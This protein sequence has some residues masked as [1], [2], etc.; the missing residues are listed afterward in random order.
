MKAMGLAVFGAPGPPR[1]AYKNRYFPCVH[2]MFVDLEQVSIDR[3]DFEPDYEDV[4]GHARK[5]DEPDRDRQPSWPDPAK[6]RKRRFVGTS[7]DVSSRIAVRLGQRL[8][9]SVKPAALVRHDVPL[10]SMALRMTRSLRMQAVMRELLGLAAG[11][12]A[13]VEGADRRVVAGGDQGGHVERGADRFRPPQIVRRPR[14]SPLSRANGATPARLA[15]AL[16]S[17]RPSSGSRASRLAAVR[18]PM[19]GTEISSAARSRVAASASSRAAI[20]AAMAR[21]LRQ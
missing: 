3:L 16:A 12:Q 9:W 19:P 17:S 14:I 10:A 18:A 15:T 6:F 8:S 5:P 11:T 2:C 13:F 20:A 7:R 21:D 1:W 4:P